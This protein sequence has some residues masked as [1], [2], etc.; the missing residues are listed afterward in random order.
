MFVKHDGSQ[1]D[2]VYSGDI[3]ELDL[4]S[5]EG[6]LSGPKRPHDRV[7]FS[8]MKKDFT[9]CLTNKVGFKGF[10]LSEADTK[11]SAKFTHEGK[12]YD[13]NHGSVVIAAITS[14]T[15]TSNPDVML[16]AGLLAKNAVEKGLSV[17]P[18]IKTSLSPGSHVVTDYFEKADVQKY[19]DQ[20]GF[21][22]AG[23][24]CM[25]CIG[26]SG[27]IPDSVQ[28]CIID[29]DL[30]AAAVLSGNRNFEG[31]VHPHTRANYLA[32]P[33]L[34]VAYALS[35]SVDFDFETQPLGQ[36]QQ[37]KDVFLRDI[38][39]TRTQVQEVTNS[40]ITA[41]MFTSTYNNIL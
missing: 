15:N 11:K 30:V 10:G 37:G 13:F 27:E 18:Y 25:T 8:A 1:P 7:D 21:T 26:N 32:S 31:R 20:L 38:W 9:T 34:V 5:V 33:P 28:N 4:G 2:P 19:L 22:T 29:N 39:P 16:A 41:E 14:C 12:E 40:V 35:G 6:A 17:A 3:M 23:Y 24:G 36:D